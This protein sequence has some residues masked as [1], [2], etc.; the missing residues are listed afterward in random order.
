MGLGIVEA[1]ALSDVGV[2]FLSELER[3]KHTAQLGKVFAVLEALGLELFTAPRPRRD[4]PDTAFSTQ[5]AQ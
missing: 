2:R 3:G 1:A 5:Q 4:T